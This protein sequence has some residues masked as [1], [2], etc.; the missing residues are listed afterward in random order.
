M[1]IAIY[2]AFLMEFYNVFSWSNEEM[3]GI[4]PSIMEHEIRTYPNVIPI[5]QNLCPMNSRKA[6][7]IKDE[8]ERM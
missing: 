7:V 2:T 6:T 8:V 4:D 3:S 1:E 5:Q